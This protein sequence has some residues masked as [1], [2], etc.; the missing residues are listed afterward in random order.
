MPKRLI[1]FNLDF[2]KKDILSKFEIKQFDNAIIEISPFLDNLSY[3]VSES[4]NIKLYV[5]I[6][7]DVFKQ[8]TNIN[9]Q[10]NKIIIDL[11][12]NIIATKGKA[13]AE[14]ELS[15]VEGV[16]TSTTFIFDV[17][18]KV[19]EGSVVAGGTEGLIAKYQRLLKEFKQEQQLQLDDINKT[20]ESH[21][22][23]LN[24]HKSQLEQIENKNIE[25]D[26][27]LKEVE[28]KN[29]VQDVY[30]SGL[31]NENK[32]G[33]L[34]VEGEGNNL[35]LEGSKEGL[36]EVDKIVGDTF[37]NLI[38]T[39]ANYIWRGT[40][41]TST[42][43]DDASI[44]KPNTI[45]T[46]IFNVSDLALDGIDYISIEAQC[47]YFGR[48]GGSIGSVKSNGKHIFKIELFNRIEGSLTNNT[49][50]I[51]GSSGQWTGDSSD[52]TITIGDCVLLEGDYTNKPIPSEY[53]EGMQSTFEEC[54]VTQEMVDVGEE[55][56]EN[57][58]KYKCNVKIRGKN[59]F[60]NN[61]INSNASYEVVNDRR[62]Y[63]VKVKANTNYVLKGKQLTDT[64]I[65]PSC[66][67]W[68]SST[69]DLQ[70]NSFLRLYPVTNTVDS[71]LV[72]SNSE[73]Y[74]YIVI[75]GYSSIMSNVI[76][77]IQNTIQLE[78]GTQ[79]TAYEPYVERTQKV[80]LNSPLLKGDEI[81]AKEDGLYHYH[82]RGKELF[83]GSID[84]SWVKA[85][86]N[87][88]GIPL[89]N[90]SFST[91]INTICDKLIPVSYDN[92][93][94]MNSVYC[95]SENLY[96]RVVANSLSEYKQWLQANPLTVVYELAEPYYE[97]ISDDKLLLEIPNSATLSVESII[98]CQNISATY[99]GN[100][101]SV[102]GLEETNKN[103]DDLIDITLCATDE[104]Y[105]MLEPILEAMP[106]TIKNERMV[107][108][109]VD[110][111]VAMVIR[112]LKTIEEVPA[113]YRKE[114]QD[115][116]NKLEK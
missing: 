45:Y 50:V 106:Q 77:L 35:K 93:N 25:Q 28:H 18:D 111:Y 59:L 12:K 16:T 52:R 3:T 69:K 67:L 80:Y 96:T 19:G 11:D 99:T 32:D 40:K 23:Q 13:L 10:E 57:L 49:L 48:N 37:V 107:S 83:D 108:K 44:L 78:E 1:K 71:K 7:N 95:G 54:K 73:G 22:E 27:R 75:T 103:Q 39:K 100:V 102:Y 88:W 84:E 62:V 104:M 101:P 61:L 116:L 36:V 63:P 38:K 15:D 70:P 109:M 43:L 87:W 68:L 55:L 97:K 114:V 14:L 5:C 2:A 47:A 79:A 8:E 6:S 31:F 34:S 4:T 74:L 9:I 17:E 26:T 81:V 24:N 110:M 89:T 76:P 85:D 46:I 92:R 115:I 105:M 113:R 58:G 33:R 66:S 91:S 30:I 21:S 98:P 90:C 51:K 41:R 20:L 65:A 64:N 60:D 82:S 53:F 29:K 94:T 72:T 56:E 86:T 112:G 42:V